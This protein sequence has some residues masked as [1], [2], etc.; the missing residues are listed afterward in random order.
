M[1]YVNPEREIFKA[2]AVAKSDGPV[3]MLN[4]IKLKETAEYEDGTSL[5]ASEAYAALQTELKGNDGELQRQWPLLA[6][7]KN[8]SEEIPK[9]SPAE[10]TTNTIYS[11]FI[12]TLFT[13][14]AFSPP[15]EKEGPIAQSMGG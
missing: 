15:W 8:W 9:Y 12:G 2:F 11:Y 10:L 14:V 4:L 5:P 3:H 13:F 6:Q 1:D 7:S